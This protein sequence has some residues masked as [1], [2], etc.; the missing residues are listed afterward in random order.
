MGEKYLSI[1]NHF[2][3]VDVRGKLS[4]VYVHIRGRRL[5]PLCRKLKIKYANALVGFKERGRKAR[6]GWSPEL[7]GVV[8]SNRSAPKLLSAIEERQ[9]QAASR[10]IVTDEARKARRERRQ[11]Q[12]EARFYKAILMRFPQIPPEEAKEISE[13]TCEIGSGRVGRSGVVGIEAAVEL[14]VQAH[15]RHN[16][17]EYDTLLYDGTEEYMT[18]DERQQLRFEARE[19]VSNRIDEIL[20]QWSGRETLIVSNS[21]TGSE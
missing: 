18:D 7:D 20:E 3:S 16:H 4:K 9:K 8:V 12:D 6:F 1:A 5:Q 11:K 17:T 15:V 13:H 2:G 10:P 14:A 19:Q 21:P